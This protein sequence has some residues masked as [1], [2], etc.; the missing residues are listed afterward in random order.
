MPDLLRV[1]RIAS[2]S[3]GY[4][5]TLTHFRAVCNHWCT[6]S[7]FG[8]KRHP[9]RFGC[10]YASDQLGHTIS[11]S[12]FWQHFLNII[13]HPE[14]HI[15]EESALLLSSGAGPFTDDKKRVIMLGVHICFLCF[16]RVRHSCIL[17]RRLVTQTLYKYTRSH[18]GAAR[19]LR[20]LLNTDLSS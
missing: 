7:R 18:I 6:A 8:N 11:C 1:Y 12:V 9:C 15:D 3:I 17:T 20:R 14:L 13:N 16:N 2:K 4:A 5:A 10:G 19:L